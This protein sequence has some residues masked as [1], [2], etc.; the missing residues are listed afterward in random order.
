MRTYIAFFTFYIYYTFIQQSLFKVETF[1][2]LDGT[3]KA[4]ALAILRVDDLE[5][6]CFLAIKS[7][8]SSSSHENGTQKIGLN[9][10]EMCLFYTHFICA[11]HYA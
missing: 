7:Y 11:L 8:F 4:S 6:R 5:S 2:S 1:R 3:I 9:N 10:H